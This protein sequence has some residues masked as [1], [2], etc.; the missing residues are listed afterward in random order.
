MRIAFT[1]RAPILLP[2][3][4]KKNA[5]AVHNT[6][7]PMAAASPT[8]CDGIHLSLLRGFLLFGHCFSR[9]MPFHSA[10]SYPEVIVRYFPTEDFEHIGQEIKVLV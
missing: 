8:K 1:L 3:N 9:I 7:V 6:E 4:A 2:A 10:T 5:P